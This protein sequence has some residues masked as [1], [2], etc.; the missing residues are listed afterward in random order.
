MA[1]L[2]NFIVDLTNYKERFGS[3][4]PEGTY[5]VK[6]DDA[7]LDTSKAGNQMINLWFAIQGG[8][9][10]GMVITDRVVL[11]DKAMF[12]VVAFLSAIGMST[13]KQKH[14]L[15]LRHIIGKVL[16]VTVEDGEP[17]NGNIRSEVRQYARPAAAVSAAQS[18]D[19]EDDLDE[20]PAEEVEPETETEQEEVPASEEPQPTVKVTSS[21]TSDEVDLDDIDEL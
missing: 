13:K 11:S 19:L 17:Y 20:N 16:E 18:E 10:D 21:Q 6:V 4:V 8:E 7:E 5:R 14:A 15:S 2:D 12:R 1:P 3:K 9:Y